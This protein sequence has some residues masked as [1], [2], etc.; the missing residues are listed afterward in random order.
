MAMWLNVP[1]RA[2]KEQLKPTEFV[3][4]AGEV[5]F[6]DADFGQMLWSLCSGAAHG[7]QWARLSLPDLTVVSRGEGTAI[8][9]LSPSITRMAMVAMAAFAM[10]KKGFELHARRNM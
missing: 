1:L 6:D 8:V 7:D 3:R 5:V 4:G 10:V 2:V 9:Y